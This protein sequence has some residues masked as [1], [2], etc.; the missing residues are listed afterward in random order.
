MRQAA[1]CEK[2]TFLVSSACAPCFFRK[3]LTSEGERDENEFC[4]LLVVCVTACALRRSSMKAVVSVLPQG[5]TNREATGAPRFS[6]RGVT[7]DRIHPH[8]TQK[9]HPASARGVTGTLHIPNQTRRKDSPVPPAQNTKRSK[10]GKRASAIVPPVSRIEEGL[11][12]SGEEA[13][14]RNHC[15][16]SGIGFHLVG[17]SR[18]LVTT[19]PLRA[20][21]KP[22]S[23]P[24]FKSISDTW[25]MRRARV[26]VT[27][28]PSVDRYRGSWH[29]SMRVSQHLGFVLPVLLSGR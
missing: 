26:V 21:G 23:S 14:E 8:R 20:I 3:Y 24:T 12:C 27:G 6:A 7:S 2:S 18:A 29:P 11:G 15:F 5:Q 10:G 28:R 19:V 22:G 13:G 17:L 9:R 1:N 16:G 25:C 4:A